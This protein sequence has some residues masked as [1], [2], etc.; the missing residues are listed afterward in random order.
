MQ[1]H[2]SNPAWSP[3]GASILFDRTNCDG[4][5]FGCLLELMVVKTDGSREETCCFQSNY[6]GEPAWSPEGRKIAFVLGDSIFVAR[7]DWTNGTSLT[8]GFSPAW[9]R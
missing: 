1:E 8:V 6:M 2:D 3:D 5:G 7:A 9:R 4:F